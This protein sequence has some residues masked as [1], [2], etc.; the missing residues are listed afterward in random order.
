MK[1]RKPFPGLFTR[2][3]YF[4]WLG[5]QVMFSRSFTTVSQAAFTPGGLLIVTFC[6]TEL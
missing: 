4:E 5:S 3:L 6:S 2:K 1:R